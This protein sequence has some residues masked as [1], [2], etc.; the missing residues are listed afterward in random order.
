MRQKAAV[1]FKGSKNINPTITR[2]LRANYGLKK[3]FDPGSGYSLKCLII[4]GLSSIFFEAETVAAVLAAVVPVLIEPEY[5]QMPQKFK[6]ARLVIPEAIASDQRWYVTYYVYNA[7]K[8]KVVRKR[9][10][11]CNKI[12]DLKKRKVWALKFIA[13]I[14]QKLNEGFHIDSEKLAAQD[15][16][17]RAKNKKFISIGEAMQMAL[18]SKEKL[19]FKTYKNYKDYLNGWLKFA[20]KNLHINS[21]TPKSLKPFYQH[22][23][24]KVGPRTFN[25]YVAHISTLF[26]YLVSEEIIETNPWVKAP[27]LDNGVGKNLAYQK[28]QQK[29]LLAY[30]EEHFPNMKLYCETIYYTLA[31]PNEISHLQIKHL[32]MYRPKHLFIP[33]AISKNK[34]DRHVALPEPIYK[35]LIEFKKLP[36]DWYLFGKGIEPGPQF[37][38]ARNVTDAYRTRVI[39]KLGYASDYTLYSWKHT[40]VVNNYMAGLS[41]ASLRMQIGHNDT[42]S[43]EKYL[44][45]LGLFENKEVM[46]NYVEL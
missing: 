2:C 31:R 33:A 22:L 6:D 45:S 42:G 3:I 15:L 46:E 12:E 32:E 19:R 20:D 7:Q 30:M 40:G 24:N 29:E 25:N 44:K 34:T 13:A 8:G 38:E 41:P 11:Q 37:M 36:A 39:R 10:Y 21:V 17:K 1:K 14:N 9:D 16:E 5:N 35:K 18:K 23:E 28:E 43:F 26:A 4:L 27:K